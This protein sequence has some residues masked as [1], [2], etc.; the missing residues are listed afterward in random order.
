MC[1]ECSLNPLT[2]IEISDHVAGSSAL[3]GLRFSVSISRFMADMITSYFPSESKAYRNFSPSGRRAF[4]RNNANTALGVILV[5]EPSFRV[6]TTSPIDWR[7][8]FIAG[9]TVASAVVG[10]LSLLRKPLLCRWSLMPANT[11]VIGFISVGLWT[12]IAIDMDCVRSRSTAANIIT[13]GQNR[14]SE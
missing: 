11:I 9:H 6:S 4:P 10:S 2:A 14:D 3:S 7:I 1:S 8:S 5:K 13:S 12:P